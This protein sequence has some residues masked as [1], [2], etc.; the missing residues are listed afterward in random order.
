MLSLGSSRAGVLFTV[1][2]IGASPAGAEVVLTFGIEQRLEAGRN[3]DL[4]VP[5]EGRT[6]ASVTRLSFGAVS[7]TPLD[8]LEFSA[9]G[10]LLVENTE[11]GTETGFDRPDMG[12][13]Y[14]REVPNALFTIG[15]RY[16]R[17]DIDAFDEDL[18]AT[19]LGGTRSDTS[20]DVRLE[21]GRIAP[22]GLAFSAE[23]LK[24][25]Y[26]DTTDPELVDTKTARVGA[27]ATLRFTEVLEGT[28]GLAF[29]RET[30]ADTPGISFETGIVSVGLTYLLANGSATADLSG[31]SDDEEGD[32]TSFVLGRTFVLP[33]ATV[34]ARIGATDGEIGGT[35]VIGSLTWEQALPSGSLDLLVDR[36]VSFDEDA[37]ESVTETRASIA[38]GYDINAVS[39]LGLS[40][41]HE[42]ADAP[43]E[44]STLSQ[45]A[46]TYRYTLT[47]DWG[48]D[49]GVRF[50]VRHDAEGRSESPDVFVA[51]SRRIEFRP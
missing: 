47:E 37:I 3:V 13:R 2:V 9:A 12:L 27:E 26:E 50:R 46:A 35:D 44:R 40:L 8:V 20:A 7:R 48:L 1:A 34:T 16:R 38:W 49:G 4:T 28:V 18:A 29:E 41:S 21:T 30:R 6:I 5:E 24:T 31:S 43:S 15:T 17:D 23:Y 14:T 33:A 51:L 45:F 11:A 32:R 22:L 10:A 42:I 19:D 25:E 36:S 39:S